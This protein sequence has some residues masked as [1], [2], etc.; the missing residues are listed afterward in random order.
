[1]A[2]CNAGAEVPAYQLLLSSRRLT[3][4]GVVYL[5]T[6]FDCIFAYPWLPRVSYARMGLE[7]FLALLSAR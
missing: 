7:R 1:M 4:A 3:L 2:G 6:S 5:S